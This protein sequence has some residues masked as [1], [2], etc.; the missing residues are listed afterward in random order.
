MSLPVP[1]A[2]RVGDRH[3]TREV[4][5][6]SFRR[7]AIGGVRSI[8]FSLAR[9][10][11]DL[12]G[13]D[14]LA[15]VYVYDGRT[16]ETVAEGRLADTGRG[17]SANGQQWDCVAFGP[18]QHASDI[19]SP[20][21]YVDRA[22]EGWRFYTA[23][24][25]GAGATFSSGQRPNVAAGDTGLLAAW[26]DGTQVV[27]GSTVAIRYEGVREAGMKLA[28][29]AYDRVNGFT[30]ASWLNEA[31]ISTAGS[32]GGGDFEFKSDT[33]STVSGSTFA[34]VGTDFTN[35]RDVVDLRTAWGGGAATVIGD[36]AWGFF[37]PVVEA[38]RMN[39]KGTE[40][41]SGYNGLARTFQIVADLLGRMLPEFDGASATID[42]ASV[43]DI[44]QMTYPGGVTAAQV[45]DDLMALVP[46]YRWYTTPDT[47]GNGYGFRWETWPTEVRYEATLEDGGSFPLS[48]QQVYNGVI[49]QWTDPS[50]RPRTSRVTAANDL[51]G[52]EGLTRQTAIDLGAEVGSEAN[53]AA[54]GAAFLDEHSVPKN[55]GTL[56]VSRPIRDVISGSLVQP[57]EIEAGELV[58]ILGVEAYPDAFN[59]SSND[60]RGVFRIHA[61]DYTSEG[62]AATLALDSDPRDTESAL[63]ALMEQRERR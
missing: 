21:I 33:W 58:R 8:S 38:I 20:L 1:L 15:K 35:G 6:L 4:Q 40:V 44:D 60:G 18:A 11:A 19:T 26:A 63:V 41:V 12:D 55:A 37:V 25:V 46:G 5:S 54:A 53:A 59:T 10:L 29:I 52:A 62:N 50:G 57:W 23:S 51:L 61:V 39:Q 28:R 48:T 13:L 31:I 30:S 27:L 43:Y 3:I 45:F 2:V 49:V 16:A 7:E 32:W 9:S 36:T 14:P 47:T 42:T 24:S 22:V 56:T 34:E 17:A